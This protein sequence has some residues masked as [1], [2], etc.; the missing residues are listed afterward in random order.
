MEE[1]DSAPLRSGQ[2]WCNNQSFKPLCY[3]HIHIAV[4]VSSCVVT[5]GKLNVTL[6]MP[7]ER[8]QYSLRS[9]E[10]QLLAGKF[11]F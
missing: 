4:E 2:G 10:E 3:G 1:Q 9:R 8:Y 11:L 5:F 6:T 7:S